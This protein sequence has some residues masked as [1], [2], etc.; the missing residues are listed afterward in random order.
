MSM[1]SA[2]ALAVDDKLEFRRLHGWRPAG[3]AQGARPV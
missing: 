1:P 2:L 3:F